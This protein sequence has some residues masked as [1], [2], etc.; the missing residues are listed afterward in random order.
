MEPV[1]MEIM[2]SNVLL[3]NILINL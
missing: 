3:N 2:H 1:L